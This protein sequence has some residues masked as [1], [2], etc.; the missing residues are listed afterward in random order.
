MPFAIDV[1]LQPLMGELGTAKNFP[2]FRLYEMPVY[3]QQIND[4]K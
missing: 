4:E 3:I 1:F 2:N